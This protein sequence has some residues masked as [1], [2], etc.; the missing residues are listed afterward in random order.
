MRLLFGHPAKVLAIDVLISI[1]IAQRALLKTIQW[2]VL[3]GSGLTLEIAELLIE[4]SLPE[5]LDAEGY[6]SFRELREALGYSGGLL[7]RRIGCLCDSLWAETKRAAPNL[8][9][10]VHGNSQKVRIT[11][12]GRNK[13]AP[14]WRKYELLA[15]ELLEG[16]SQAD[17]EAHY[18][19]NKQIC[20]KIRPQRLFLETVGLPPLPLTP[21]PEPVQEFLD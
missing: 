10:G 11:D 2:Q 6:L 13:I 9:R 20:D 21:A 15:E 18:R 4:L 1:G 12:C 17:R 5:H 16:V 19:L 14:I 8:E 7:S 3:A